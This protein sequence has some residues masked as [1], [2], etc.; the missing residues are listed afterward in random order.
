L[1]AR[2]GQ[3]RSTRTAAGVESRPE[4]FRPQ[5]LGAPVALP[6]A[7]ASETAPAVER[8]PKAEPKPAEADKPVATT[9]RLLEAKKRA[10]KRRNG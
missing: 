3:V 4:L 10:Q 2:R 1:L 6:G 7:D 5:Q 8:P 9:S